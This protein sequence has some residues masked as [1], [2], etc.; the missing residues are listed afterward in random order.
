MSES[1]DCNPWGLSDSEIELLVVAANSRIGY[2][3]ND[4]NCIRRF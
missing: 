2:N 3:A 4:C 1:R